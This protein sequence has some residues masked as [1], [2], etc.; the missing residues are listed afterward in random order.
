LF[1]FTFTPVSFL[2]GRIF[3]FS[4]RLTVTFLDT[5]TINS[6][7]QGVNKLPSAFTSSFILPLCP[8]LKRL[9]FLIGMI[10]LPFL[11]SPLNIRFQSAD[12][13]TNLTSVS[14]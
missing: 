1:T 4:F 3:L 2:I 14:F 9:N 13:I 6:S 12:S 8:S 11:T 10:H 7:F 5:L